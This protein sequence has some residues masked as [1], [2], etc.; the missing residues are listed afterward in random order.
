MT[1]WIPAG[2]EPGS[3][4]ERV[5][6]ST[7]QAE[8]REAIG[9]AADDDARLA[10]AAQAGANLADLSDPAA[11]LAQLKGARMVG[12]FVE[13]E[14]ET[15]GEDAKAVFTA[16]H[17]RSG[18]GAARYV[19]DADQAS[20]T[21]SPWR[22]RSADG[23]WFV[24]DEAEPSFEQFGALGQADHLNPVVDDT[25]AI[26]GGAVAWSNLTGRAVRAGGRIYNVRD[27][28]EL[29][30]GR[31]KGVGSTNGGNGALATSCLLFSHLGA[32]PGIRTTLATSKKLA[33]IEGFDLRAASWDPATGCTGYGLDIGARLIA[34]DL[35]VQH[36]GKSGLFLH[37]DGAF[38]GAATGGPYHSRFESCRFVFSKEHGAVVGT[39]ANAVTFVDCEW[40]WNGAPGYGVAPSAAGSWDGLHVAYDGDGNPGNAYAQYWPEALTVLG[41]DASYNSRYGYNFQGVRNSPAIMPGYAEQ[42][43]AADGQ[44]NIGLGVDHCFIVFGGLSGGSASVKMG[45][46]GD[47]QRTN[48]IWVGGESLGGGGTG[49]AKLNYQ[50][51]AG[52]VYA[53]SPDRAHQVYSIASDNKTYMWGVNTWGNG[54]IKLG[55][56]QAEYIQ[57]DRMAGV[58]LPARSRAVSA[59]EFVPLANRASVLARTYAGDSTAWLQAAINTG[60]NVDLCGLDWYCAGLTI[61]NNQQALISPGGTANLFKNANG[62]ILTVSGNDV[63]VRDVVFRGQSATFTG[64][65]VVLN[66][67][68]PRLEFCGS[69]DAQARAL[70]G[71]TAD[72]TQIY[73]YTYGYQTAD[74]SATGYDIELGNPAAATLY[75][76]IIGTYGSANGGILLVNSGSHSITDSLFG[77]LTVQNI[78]SP[79][80]SNGGKM[81]GNRILG[82][83]SVGLPSA[84]FVGNQFGAITV[85]LELGSGGCSIDESNTWQSGSLVVN[86]GN[87]SSN[88]IARS[89]GTGARPYNGPGTKYGATADAVEVVHRNGEGL[90][91]N[92]NFLLSN[93]RALKSRNSADAAD[94]NLISMSQATDSVF[95]GHGQ[96]GGNTVIDSGTNGVRIATANAAFLDLK[97]T[98]VTP[99]ATNV[100]DLGTTALRFKRAFFQGVIETAGQY[101]I[102]GNKVVGPRDTGWTISTGIASKGAYATYA[103]GTASAAYTQTELQDVMTKLQAASQRVKAL[104][105]AM[106]THG[107]ID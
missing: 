68:R 1:E 97:T 46:Y 9:A 51:G 98:G 102:G 41:G 23:F 21:A 49:N 101:N 63:V 60:K 79:P 52:Q 27:T 78:G 74:T 13:L 67:L 11:A 42:N 107:L 81:S 93:S 31:L 4:G 90:W 57:I 71:P 29:T 59:L 45:V 44:V 104:E 96:G 37:G 39:G 87:G 80:G 65:N 32:K 92:W 70:Y 3:V 73:G 16:G 14:G 64:H 38:G 10:G 95:V 82:N 62:A 40:K 50:T 66:G 105:D 26:V 34:R 47:Y 69:L 15:V 25:A 77:K 8:A 48:Q 100:L 94:L 35:S 56:N 22:G 58:Q 7:S 54:Q 53:E 12:L 75:H 24:L 106:R 5:Y 61:P 89:I 91:T 6:A 17:T 103:A 18:L 76:Q 19:L 36:W 30:Y 72:K 84:I 43:R 85:T 20:P 28:I 33:L 99:A 55:A 86:N 83:V 2:L 88:F